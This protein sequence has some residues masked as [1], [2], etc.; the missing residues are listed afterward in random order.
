MQTEHS[1]ASSVFMTFRVALPGSKFQFELRQVLNNDDF[2]TLRIR[3]SPRTQKQS[4][5][6]DYTSRLAMRFQFPEFSDL[7][8]RI[9]FSLKTTSI[10]ISNAFIVKISG[11]NSLKHLNISSESDPA[12]GMFGPF[13]CKCHRAEPG[14]APRRHAMP[15]DEMRC[16]ATPAHGKN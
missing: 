14:D 7:Y 2:Q 13:E 4:R 1:F 5:Q 10:I 8:F 12:K 15:G 16:R 11:I 9:A 3:P 6:N